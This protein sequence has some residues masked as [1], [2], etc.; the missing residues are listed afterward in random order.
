M[1]RMRSIGRVRLAAAAALCVLLAMSAGCGFCFFN[2][3][4][5]TSPD[6]CCRNFQCTTCALWVAKEKVPDAAADKETKDF[7]DLIITLFP[8]NQW[9]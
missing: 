3:T 4:C 9:Q 7:V 6:M 8:P 2:A 5:G 1:N